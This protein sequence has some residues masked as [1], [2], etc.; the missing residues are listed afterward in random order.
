MRSLTQRQAV[1]CETA[2]TPRC[3]CRC[4]GALHGAYRSEPAGLQ[5]ILEYVVGLPEEDPHYVA[6]KTWQPKLPSPVGYAA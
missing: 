5:D 2:R 6:N 3:R 1:L 4:G